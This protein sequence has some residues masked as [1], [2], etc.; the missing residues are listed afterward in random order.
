ME[1]RWTTHDNRIITSEQFPGRVQVFRYITDAEAAARKGPARRGTEGR[2]FPTRRPPVRRHSKS[3]AAAK[4]SGL[5]CVMNGKE[6]WLSQE[7][8]YGEESGFG[9]LALSGLER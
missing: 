8:Q 4:T 6:F 3:N 7:S 5:G 1:S 9:R 2:P